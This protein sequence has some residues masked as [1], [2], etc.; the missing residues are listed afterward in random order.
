LRLRALLA[1]RFDLQQHIET[2][3]MPAY[4]MAAAREGTLGPQ[5]LVSDA[6]DRPAPD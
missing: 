6:L 4:G 2:R 5:L 1:D 3:E